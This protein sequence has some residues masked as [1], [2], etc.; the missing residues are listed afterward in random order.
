MLHQQNATVRAG[1]ADARAQR[2]VAALRRPHGIADAHLAATARDRLFDRHN[3]ANV[4]SRAQ[5]EVGLILSA[6][7]RGKQSGGQ[8]IR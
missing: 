6:Q 5:I 3:A 7:R 8:K 2:R 1:D 4:L